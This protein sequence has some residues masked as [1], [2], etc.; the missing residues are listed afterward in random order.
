MKRVVF[1]LLLLLII[2]SFF[3]LSARNTVV[4]TSKQSVTSQIS[5]SDKGAIYIVR[6]SIDLNNKSIQLPQNAVLQFEGGALYNGDLIGNNATIVAGRYELF[7]TVTLTGNWILDGVPVEWFG[8]IP[9]D[10][11]QDCSEA[12][13]TTINVGRKISAPALLGSG[14]YYTQKTIDIPDYGTLIGLSPSLTRICYYADADV[15]VYMHG[16]YTTIRNIC[17]EE[18]ELGRKGICIKLGDRKTNVS[19]TRGFV[20][21]VKAIGGDCGLDLEYQWCNKISGVNCRYN[22]TGLYAYDT[23]PY[24]ENAVIEG[25]YRYGVYSEGFGIKLYNATI[26]GNRI[27][28]VLNGKYNLLNN[29]YFEGNTASHLDKNATKNLK[30][31]DIEGGNLYVGDITEVTDLVM[32]SCLF[33]NDSKFNNTIRIDK[34]KNLT[35]MGCSSLKYLE[36]T[37]NCTVKYADV[38]YRN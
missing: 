4:L 35:I 9:N 29:C 36:T 7:K 33:V 6:E 1:L 14:V 18:N 13:N 8:A 25:N 19:S 12:I 26:E 15:G 30:G 3:E 38:P 17:V 21:D 27:G 20:E 16:Q 11:N 2:G 10:V 28:C 23:T 24:V 32:I 31:A 34:C 22:N 37:K 5:S